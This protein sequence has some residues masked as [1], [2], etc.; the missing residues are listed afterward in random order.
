MK[1]KIWTQI[2][3]S[4]PYEDGGGGWSDAA[5]SQGTSVIAGCHQKLEEAKKEPLEGACP[6]QHLDLRLPASRTV[7]E[8]ISVVLSHPVCGTVLQRPLET[9]MT[10]LWKKKMAP[11]S[12]MLL[13]LRH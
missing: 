10:L 1:R 5:T 6:C 3:E 11:P 9:N 13:Q 4:W 7:S 8:Y 2:E 12:E